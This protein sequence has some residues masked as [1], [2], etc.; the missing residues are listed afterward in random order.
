VVILSKVLS[1]ETLLVDMEAIVGKENVTND[2]YNRIAYA[3]DPMPYDLKEQ[4]IPSIVVKPNSAQEV[5]EILKYANK[6]KTP[7]SVTG[8]GTS[9]SA[10]SRPKRRGSIIMNTGRMDSIELHEDSAY[11]E[12]GAG[13]IVYDFEQFLLSHGYF[14]PFNPGSKMIATMGG[15]SSINTIGHMVDAYVGKPVDHIL[16][17]EV[18]LP[19]GEIIETGTKSVRRPSGFDLTRFFVGTEGQLGIITRL[20][21]HLIPKPA[22]VYALGYYEQAEDV[23]EAFMRIYTEKAPLPLYGEFL[24]KVVA[25]IGTDAKGLPPPKGCMA[26]AS[27]PG[28]THD[29]ALRNAQEISK[30]FK[31]TKGHIENQI[32]EDPDLQQRLWGVRESILM[33][34]SKGKGPWTAIEIGVEISH[35]RNCL[36]ELKSEV[37]KRLNILKDVPMYLYGHLGAGSMHA[38]WTLPRGWSNEKKREAVKEAFNVEKELTI[39]YNGCGGE[40]GQVAG[41]IPFFREKYGEDAY[42]LILRMKKAFDPNN[43]LNPGNLEGSM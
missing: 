11:V 43:I 21:M 35:L 12:C 41:R 30:V 16:G 23:A 2:I 33:L 19:T 17:V 36:H 4:N 24:D 8:S 31:E 34:M 22:I 1:S 26:L 5:S 20:R 14:A 9:F 7:V 3:M 42:S 18:V 37:P 38:L 25:K 29:I 13:T 6:T 40:L 28:R 27:V 15:L 39:K 10:A 32:V